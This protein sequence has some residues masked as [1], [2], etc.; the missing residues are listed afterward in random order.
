MADARVN[1]RVEERSDHTLRLLGI[2]MEGGLC[3]HAVQMALQ[4]ADG[5]GSDTLNSRAEIFQGM[6]QR[7][8]R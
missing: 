2:C 7:G 6:G 8:L 1:E 3:P 4:V 5:M